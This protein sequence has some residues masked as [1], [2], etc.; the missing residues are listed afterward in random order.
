MTQAHVKGLLAH[1]LHYRHRE[2]ASLHVLITPIHAQ[3]QVE[4]F[5]GDRQEIAVFRLAPGVMAQAERDGA[6][7][8]N[9]IN[10]CAPHH[11]RAFGLNLDS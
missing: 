11:E 9:C 6:V 5:V 2:L 7:G 8:I 10:P 4:V 1:L 3:Q